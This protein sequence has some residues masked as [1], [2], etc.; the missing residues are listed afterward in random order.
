MNIT[1]NK[2]DDPSFETEWKLIQRK[3]KNKLK[4]WFYMH[5]LKENGAKLAFLSLILLLQWPIF[6]QNL[7]LLRYRILDSLL[8]INL[9]FSQ[10][11]R[12]SWGFIAY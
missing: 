2:L 7:E 10:L 6:G 9:F 5:H 4:P 8:L 12:I 1:A 11:I 3:T